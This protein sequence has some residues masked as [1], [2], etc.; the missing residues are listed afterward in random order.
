MKAASRSASDV[1][2]WPKITAILNAD[3]SGRLTVNGVVEELAPGDLDIARGHVLERV[4]AAA[5]SVGRAVRLH[6]TDPD[7]EWELAVHPDGHVDELAAE[8][9]EA[10]PPAAAAMP[11]DDAEPVAGPAVAAA[12]I[13]STRQTPVEPHGRRDASRNG[14]PDRVPSPTAPLTRAQRKWA[15]DPPAR[16]RGARP[17]ARIGVVLTLLAALVAATVFVATSGPDTVVGGSD[18]APPRAASQNHENVAAD[19]IADARRKGAQRRAVAAA[20]DRRAERRALQ[21]R[22]AARQ[23]RERRA[24]RR[25]L[26]RRVAAREARERR[27]AARRAAARPSTSPQPRPRTTPP[28]PPNAF[29]PPPPPPPPPARPRPCGEFDLC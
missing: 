2:H 12:A 16:R 21:R 26:E 8:P 27:A 10:A 9:I 25:A 13:A 4:A 19:A 5:A 29:A 22:V 24:A 20:A 28:P 3:G 15:G 17:A 6:S 7:G 18:P 11:D 23:A 14:G 1:P